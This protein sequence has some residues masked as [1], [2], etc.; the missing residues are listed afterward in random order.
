MDRPTG[1]GTQP[2]HDNPT[3]TFRRPAAS[4]FP[5][6]RSYSPPVHPLGDAARVAGGLALLALPVA[7]L[8]LAYLLP[9]IR[10]IQLSRIEHLGIFDD[11][12]AI[13]P[14]N[15]DDQIAGGA[16]VDGLAR[17][18]GPIL[19]T[20]LIGAVLAPLLAWVLHRSG[21]RTRAASRIVWTL[22]AVAFAPTAVTV[23][24]IAD[25]VL[26]G[27]DRE[28]GVYDWTGLLAGV[29]LGLGVLAGL[30]AQR[31]GAATGRPAAGA[32]TVAGL[33]AFALVAAGLQSFAY[34]SVSEVPGDA[35]PPVVQIFEGLYVGRNIG[36]AAAVS[37]LL[38]TILAG[39]GLAA[40]VLFLVSH[41]RID[42][43][44]GPAEPD[45]ARPLALTAGITA[46]VLALA[47]VGYF[48]LPWITRIGEGPDG[49]YDL[50]FI[51][52]QTWGPPLVTTAV[53]LATALIGG[54]AIGALRPFGDG[55][56]WLLLL[57]APWLFVGSGPLGAA[58]LEAIAEDGEWMVI[59]SFPARVWVAI[60]VLFLF[61]ALFWG[62]EDRRR[63]ALHEG[64]SEK[65][66]RRAF[67]AGA[68]PM[69]ALLGL[70][71][72]LVFGQDVFWQQITW[73]GMLSTGYMMHALEN[74][75]FEHTAV[76]LG[77]P[78]PVLA[79]VVLAAL[80]LAIWYLPKVA[81][82]VGRE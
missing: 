82:K 46:L 68:W 78:I 80:A 74:L 12:N 44:A 56:R 69:T 81:V 1:T 14:A 43:T 8:V 45:R 76:T 72:L 3:L 20:V 21:A 55:S 35:P 30:A 61:T 10:T 38:L 79:A 41:L 17:L 50:W 54:F 23:A 49:D 24:W 48:L 19:V 16:F 40:A 33:S 58:N 67:V 34:T 77:Y 51:I 64:M 15:Y 59:G 53:A 7:A 18:I 4:A 9:T 29:V 31:G 70:A 66:A 73:Q 6:P 2:P 57:F 65:D 27:S 26:S 37:V 60:P 71:L 32:L 25:R 75:D 13:G 42:V 62:L 63:A 28:L 52:R 11:S 39:L 22:A 36:T 47:A 5:P